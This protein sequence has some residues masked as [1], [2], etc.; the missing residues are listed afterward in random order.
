[1]DAAITRPFVGIVAHIIVVVCGQ[2]L[3]WL[4]RYFCSSSQEFYFVS[5]R[6]Y[7]RAVGG[8]SGSGLPIFMLFLTMA[9]YGGRKTLNVFCLVQHYSKAFVLQEEST[10]FKIAFKLNVGV[11]LTLVLHKLHLCRNNNRQSHHNNSCQ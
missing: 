7:Y 8:M 5:K 6:I 1:M 2:F 11:P 9:M 10:R 3:F 4:R